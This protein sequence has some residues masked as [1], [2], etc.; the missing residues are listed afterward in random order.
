M[1]DDG[2]DGQTELVG[3]LLVQHPLRHTNQNLLLTRRQLIAL[4]RWLRQPRIH[5]RTD[6]TDYSG[7]VIVQRDRPVILSENV[8]RHSRPLQSQHGRI[9]QFRDQKAT[10]LTASEIEH[11]RIHNDH[12]RIQ[13]PQTRLPWLGVIHEVFQDKKIPLPGQDTFEPSGHNV[14]RDD[15]HYFLPILHLVQVCSPPAPEYYS[16]HRYAS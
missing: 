13:N 10:I 7:S 9:A 6:L 8:L 12:I 15:E 4:A 11:R 16:Q 14:R 1:R 3:D 5:G 2:V